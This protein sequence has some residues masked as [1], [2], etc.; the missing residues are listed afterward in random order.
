MTLKGQSACDAWNPA[1]RELTACWAVAAAYLR[2]GYKSAFDNEIIPMLFLETLQFVQQP[3]HKES[4]R[5]GEKKKKNSIRRAAN[6]SRKQTAAATTQLS[7]TKTRSASSKLRRAEDLE[8]SP[9]SLHTPQQGLR[10]KAWHSFNERHR[11][12]HKRQP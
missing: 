2:T 10:S 4:G 6:G 11:H 3:P 8:S 5:L 7:K 12:I 9:A 1:C